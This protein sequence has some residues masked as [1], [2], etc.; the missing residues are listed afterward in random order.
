MGVRG[1]LTLSQAALHHDETF[2]GYMAK[3]LVGEIRN[4]AA[5]EPMG[6]TCFKKVI[7]SL[8]KTGQHVVVLGCLA[9]DVHAADDVSSKNTITIHQL[10]FYKIF[11]FLIGNTAQFW[12]VVEVRVHEGTL[13][14]F[15]HSFEEFTNSQ[16][17][18]L[19]TFSSVT[20]VG[21]DQQGPVA[22]KIKKLKKTKV[23]ES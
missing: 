6:I 14:H 4:F 23:A 16:H 21:E 3:A 20:A 11:G 2:N 1:C 7:T 22:N 15:V 17:D 19:M 12:N 9:I 5:S 18:R 13:Q 10:S 8:T